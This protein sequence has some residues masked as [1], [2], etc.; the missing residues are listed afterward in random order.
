MKLAIERP[1]LVKSLVLNGTT[2]GG[3][4]STP[5]ET[6]F[7]KEF[8]SLFNEW[9][10]VH[11]DVSELPLEQ[12]AKNRDIVQR[13][14]RASFASNQIQNEK[15]FEN[16]CNS[17]TTSGTRLK[18]GILN[19]LAALGRFNVFGDLLKLN[20]VG[21]PV[22][23]IHGEE[24]SVIPV[25]NARTMSSRISSSRLLVLPKVGHLWQLS[26]NKVLP[27]LQ[28]FFS[29]GKSNLRQGI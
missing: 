9:N 23:I 19:Q 4:N 8:F 3:R 27:E 25:E 13:F 7:A 21:I 16:I 5:A 14:L 15:A 20:S 18:K 6:Q 17:F 29:H 1:D 11:L 24:D 12:Q 2:F 10:D 26:N 22:L 28:E